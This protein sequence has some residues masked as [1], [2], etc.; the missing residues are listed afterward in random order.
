MLEVRDLVVDIRG[1]AC[2]A[3]SAF[4]VKAGE[5]V[6]LITVAERR[7]RTPASAPS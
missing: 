3:A 4:E 2:C 5:L 6:C 1:A 7:R